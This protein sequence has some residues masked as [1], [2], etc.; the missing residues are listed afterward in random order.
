MKS[1]A[2]FLFVTLTFGLSVSASLPEDCNCRLGVKSFIVK[3][4]DSEVI[5]WQV[6][7]QSDAHMCS[8]IILDGET[9][10]SIKSC[11][12]GHG[13]QE[14]KIVTGINRL[15]QAN[16]NNTYAVKSINFPADSSDQPDN[17][18]I[19]KLKNPINFVKG[20]AEKACVRMY[21][22]SY[23]KKWYQILPKK[24]LVT[25]FGYEKAF[26]TDIDGNHEVL[27]PSSVLKRAD[28]RIDYD[29]T[30]ETDL[31]TKPLPKILAIVMGQPSVCVYDEGSPL[32]VQ[33]DGRTFVVALSDDMV[34][35]E[36]KN[37]DRFMVCDG[38]GSF[39][40]FSA[41]DSF[42]NTLDTS[43]MCLERK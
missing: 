42:L 1:I 29:R 12:D 11:V 36:I 38:H 8:G 15:D 41:T 31:R 4:K 21:D 23:A 32:Q 5:P 16:E 6:S 37:S 43:K 33:E 20:K 34:V 35:S 10:I 26:E 18:A 40:K 14:L 3:G 7:V 9:V 22:S 24:F 39:I 28:L 25:G 13:P 30:S 27:K 2:A 19:L 17:L